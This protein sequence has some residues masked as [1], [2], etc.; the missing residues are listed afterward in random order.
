MSAIDLGSLFIV[1][2]FDLSCE[3]SRKACGAVD[4]RKFG[5]GRRF[6]F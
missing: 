5:L 4:G 1:G 3:V 6:V 2:K